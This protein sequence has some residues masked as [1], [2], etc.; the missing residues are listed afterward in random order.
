M[1]YIPKSSYGRAVL[2]NTILYNAYV[3]FPQTPLQQYIIEQPSGI[4]PILYN[5]TTGT[6][7]LSGA[8][9]NSSGNLNISASSPLIYNSTTGNLALDY[10]SEQFSVSGGNLQVAYSI[11]LSNGSLNMT[12]S[13]PLVLTTNCFGNTFLSINVEPIQFTYED[14]TL[15]STLSGSGVMMINEL[16]NEIGLNYDSTLITTGTFILPNLSVNPNMGTITISNLQN[17]NLITTNITSNEAIF[18]TITSE[19]LVASDLNSTYAIFT[20]QTCTNILCTNITASNGVSSNEVFATY[21]IG[22]NI[23]ASSIVSSILSTGNLKTTNLTCASALITGS[24]IG[25]L[26]WT[27]ASGGALNVL[28][29]T[30][31]SG[32]FSNTC[33]GNAFMSSAT[34]NNFNTT[35]TTVVNLLSTNMS[36]GY[37][38]FVSCTASALNVGYASIGSSVLVNTCIGSAL[39]SGTTINNLSG[40]YNTFS[41]TVMTNTS[42][43]LLNSTSISSGALQSGY[44][45]IG[46]SVLVNS[47]IGSTL[48]SG[49]TINNLTN[50][51]Q[52]SLN[53]LTTNGTIGLLNSTGISTTSLNLTYSTMS[54]IYSSNIFSTNLSVSNSTITNIL[55]GFVQAST[56]YCTGVVE[57]T[58]LT[59]TNSTITN[60]LSTNISSSNYNIIGQAPINFNNKTTSISYGNGLEVQSG[61]LLVNIDDSTLVFDGSEITG[62]YQGEDGIIISGNIISM[63][64]D[65]SENP[66]AN[67]DNAVNNAA[68]FLNDA[69]QAGED[70]ANMA[71][72]MENV[73]D[74]IATDAVNDVGN[75][76]AGL[77]LLLLGGAVVHSNTQ[78][79]ANSVANLIQNGITNGSTAS[80]GSASTGPMGFYPYF[81]TVYSS[82]GND[83]MINNKGIQIGTAG[84]IILSQSG[85]TINNLYSTEISTNNLVL[86][87]FGNLQLG[88]SDIYSTGANFGYM[89]STN[90]L[91]TNLTSTNIIATNITTTNILTQTVEYSGTS[92]NMTQLATSGSRITL[93]NQNATG[94]N[95]SNQFQIYKYGIPGATQQ[96]ELSFQSNTDGH[97]YINSSVSGTVSNISAIKMSQAFVPYFTLATNGNIG[98]GSGATT[99]NF[100]LDITG[101]SINTTNLLATN[102][103]FANIALS[104]IQS[105]NNS[106][107]NV[108]LTNLT[109]SNIQFSTS[110]ISNLTANN[111]T[112][113]NSLI[114]NL[115]ASNGTMTNLLITNLTASNILFSTSTITNL[116]C[117]NATVSNILAT[118]SGT[119]GDNYFTITRANFGATISTTGNSRVN[120]QDAGGNVLGI[121]YG[122]SEVATITNNSTSA[123]LIMS[124]GC[125]TSG[126]IQ[127]EGTLIA[128]NVLEGT[129]QVNNSAGSYSVIASTKNN[130]SV[131]GSTPGSFNITLL[132][133]PAIGQTYSVLNDTSAGL[134]V[135][136]NGSNIL[137]VLAPSQSCKFVCYDLT[138]EWN[139]SLLGTLNNYYIVYFN[140]PV[141]GNV[142]TAIP[143]VP[144]PYYVY[145]ATSTS[146]NEIVLTSYSPP[147]LIID[148]SN[149]Q[150][151][152]VTG[153][154]IYLPQYSTLAYGRQFRINYSCNSVGGA[155]LYVYTYGGGSVA[156]MYGSS[157][158]PANDLTCTLLSGSGVPT[159]YYN[160]TGYNAGNGS[161]S[162]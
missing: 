49:A 67:S 91:I 130:I 2:Q 14:G 123:N 113:S 149:N 30:T 11:A 58:N 4:A 154:K 69:A 46:S 25:L 45:T 152:S 160:W 120:I 20:D 12:A 100:T 156:Q 99:P 151:S 131:I 5:Q 31:G 139:Q 161:I 103:S 118:S 147:Y 15:T 65:P 92:L 107:T 111:E 110:S 112:I 105:T 128:G 44:A 140:L 18:T 13:S 126:N 117:T 136:Y 37:A 40:V 64:T 150:S 108:V 22:T 78:G 8:G 68:N 145:M 71:Q 106:F 84:N 75:F 124:G 127:V 134:T 77:F 38:Y 85:S 81:L 116:N 26:N 16:D 148:N 125:I 76:F 41:N 89:N 104:N 34:V 132:A 138:P 157:G 9:L 102:T 42:I 50:T 28:Y 1:S 79:S 60:I 109:A 36:S 3:G 129:T 93:I 56:F 142:Y 144:T 55:G 90:L 62:N 137:A 158:V 63:S 119:L 162:A 48:I 52:T 122:S 146:T 24:S 96:N 6:I 21:I 87:S 82:T 83:V 101:G 53:T 143:T 94:A 47:C 59:G 66:G 114:T 19:N 39:I 10:N 97:Y 35:Y 27:G 32:L 72:N 73:G 33:T 70:A 74:N 17:S 95:V 115:N 141:A 135:V 51:Y 54:N 80:G 7:A 133:S 159:W 121:Y 29:S 43:G 86:S 88:T 155:N 57:T 23:T 61:S 98:I 153:N